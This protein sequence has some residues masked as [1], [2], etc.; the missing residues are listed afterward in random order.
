MSVEH[1]FDSVTDFVTDLLKRRYALPD[2]VPRQIVAS[3]FAVHGVERPE[4]HCLIAERD[5]FF[6][7]L[8]RRVYARPIILEWSRLSR[9]TVPWPARCCRRS[10]VGSTVERT[11]AAVVN[12][13]GISDRTTEHAPDRLSVELSGDVPKCQIDCR[14]SS[15]FGTGSSERRHAFVQKT[16]VTFDRSCIAAEQSR[17]HEIMNHRS[18]SRRNVIGLT[19]PDDG[20]SIHGTCVGV[21][22]KRHQPRHD[23]VRDRG[24]ESDNA[25]PTPVRMFLSRAGSLLSHSGLWI[26]HG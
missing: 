18:R 11:S 2:V 8:R 22:P 5:Q 6:G 4:L 14:E 23:V 3:V 9:I 20:H 13:N 26:G 17:G 7:K 25:R 19:M 21:N 24:F 15:Q 10:S 1:H 16:P 12:G